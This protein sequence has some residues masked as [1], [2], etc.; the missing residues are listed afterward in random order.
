MTSR[1][2][3]HAG[4]AHHEDEERHVLPRLR[5]TGAQALADRLAADHAEMTA[6]GR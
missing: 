3:L 6:S 1:V 2:V 4:P 5:A